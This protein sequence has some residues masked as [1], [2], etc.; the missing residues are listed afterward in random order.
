MLVGKGKFIVAGFF[1]LSQN[2]YVLL[3][4]S[5]ASPLGERWKISK[6]H[7]ERR[8]ECHAL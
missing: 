5:S 1:C 8:A 3:K 4:T 7:E 2:I 6:R